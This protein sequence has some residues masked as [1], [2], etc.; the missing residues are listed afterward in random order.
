MSDSQLVQYRGNCHC[1]AFRFTC[2]LPELKQPMY[3]N[4]SM[5]AKNGFLWAFTKDYTVVKGDENTTLKGYEFANRRFSFKFCPICGT[6]VLARGAD[7]RVGINIRA[8][9]DQDL[10]SLSESV[11][12]HDGASTEPQYQTPEPVAVETIFEGASVV[13]GSCHCGAVGYTLVSPEK[14][15]AMKDCN[16]SICSRDGALW[17]F[18]FPEVKYVTF[19]GLDALTEYTFAGRTTYHGFCKICGV[20]IR[21]R[22]VGRTDTALN[23]R[24]MNGFDSSS[25]RVIK[26]DYKSVRP[27]YEL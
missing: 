17:L 3:C 6:S 16:C 9:A 12:I 24:T 11:F 7:G 26:E 4:C 21:E 27:P 19:K 5:C 13:H 2:K 25:L 10:Y 22:F 1:G 15:T 18:P 14:L 8:L 20:A 23:V